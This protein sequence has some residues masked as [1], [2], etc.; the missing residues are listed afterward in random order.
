MPLRSSYHLPAEAEHPLRSIG[1]T[2]ATYAYLQTVCIGVQSRAFHLGLHAAQPR[3]PRV[4]RAATAATMPCRHLPGPCGG[5]PTMCS[6][7]SLQPWRHNTRWAGGQ[8]GPSSTLPLTAC[9]GATDAKRARTSAADVGVCGQGQAVAAATAAS[10]ERYSS[11]KW[12]GG[13]GM[14]EASIFQCASPQSCCMRHGVLQ[15]RAC[16]QN[17]AAHSDHAA[18][19]L[20]APSVAS[21]AC[22]PQANNC[23]CCASVRVS[24]ACART[25]MAA[26]VAHIPCM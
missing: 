7:S 22:H 14:Q 9:T 1:R 24:M 20:H 5:A 6:T 12:S 25:C 21:V 8:P 11:G 2:G 18:W 3:L 19:M 26:M 13:A 23:T 15:L 17:N 10:Y 4:Q 16:T